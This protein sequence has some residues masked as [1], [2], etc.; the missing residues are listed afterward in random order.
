MAA[1]GTDGRGLPYRFQK[2]IL[3]H[4]GILAI[5]AA[6]LALQGMDPQSIVDEIQNLIP[7]VEISFLINTLVYLHKG[8]RC[9]SVAM[10]GANVLKLKPCIEVIVRGGVG[11]K[12]ISGFL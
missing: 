5:E 10:L 1:A 9:S 2:P 7:K 11:G 4:L 8:G 6:E 12:K 3:R